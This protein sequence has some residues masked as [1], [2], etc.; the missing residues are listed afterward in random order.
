MD[1]WDIIWDKIINDPSIKHEY[2]IAFLLNIFQKLCSK[3]NKNDEYRHH[4]FKLYRQSFDFKETTCIII[5]KEYGI[6]LNEE[7]S[8]YISEWIE[9]YIKKESKRKMIPQSVKE[10]L[11]KKQNGLCAACGQPLGDQWGNIHV[12]HI[13]PW[14][15]VGDEL[16]DNYQDLCETC[17]RCKSSKTDYIFKKLLYL[18]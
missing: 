4:V 14:V 5:Q 17:N 15:L 6:P 13:I 16:K 1:Y 18:D 7:D 8:T 2:R 9:A 11:Y 12:D 10:E 3:M